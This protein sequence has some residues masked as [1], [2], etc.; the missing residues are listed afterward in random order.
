MS[1]DN[2][3]HLPLLREDLELLRAANAY[4]GSPTWTLHDPVSNRFFRIGAL[5]FHLLSR[6]SAQ[7]GEQLIR[8][9]ANETV[10]TPT[11]ED[12]AT[13]IQ[14][15]HTHQLTVQSYRQQSF[16]YAAQHKSYQASR[17][18]RLLSQYLFFRIP[19]FRPD[20]F[21]NRTYP[22]VRKFFSP[23]FLY[24]VTLIGIAGVYLVSRQWD[25]F[26]NTFL[27]FFTLQ[28]ILIYAVALIGTKIFHE[29]GHAYTAKHYGCRIPSMGVAFM[30]M[31]PMMYSDMSDT[32]RLHSR[33]ERMHVAAAGIMNEL[34]LA[35][36]CLF[37][38]AFLPEGILR[39][40]CFVVATTSLISSLL[41]NITP[42][43]RF[44]GYYLLSDWWG[45]DNLQRRSFQL[46]QWKLR[47]LLFG[48]IEEK[49][50]VLSPSQELKL[51]C[52]AW[53]TWLYRLVLFL[54]IA[55]LIYHFFFKLLGLILFVVEI[56]LLIL[57]PI[58]KEI[59]HWWTL[60]SSLSTNRRRLGVFLLVSVMCALFLP[61]NS[62]IQ[63][64]G[65]LTSAT[66]ATLYPSESAQIAFIAVQQGQ[67][68]EKDQ[69]LMVLRSPKLDKDIALTR[70][71][72]EFLEVRAL[73]AVANRQDQ[74]DLPVI[75]EQI[76]AEFSKL[77]GLENKQARLTLRAPFTGI[78]AEMDEV[79][80]VHQWVHHATPLCLIL[81]PH[82]A[83]IRG[84]IAENE[85][86]RIVLGQQALFY[87]EDSQLPKL[88][89]SI[90]RIDW[91]NIKNLD[92]TYLASQY[93]GDIA[94]RRHNNG[95]MVPVYGI[96]LNNVSSTVPQQEIRGDI[97]I[98]GKPVSVASRV[99]ET[100][101]SV[102]IRESGF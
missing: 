37:I 30:V 38:W 93:G 45:I 12:V 13:L 57:M 61:W 75:L 98:V 16:K 82:S 90:H 27:H 60:R 19:L 17:W 43:M 63:I 21:L 84:V 3:Q 56:L 68:V 39:S 40:V 11:H 88:T 78:V 49:P 59:Q 34:M 92:L 50:E 51:I 54:G 70:K 100:V 86:K 79:L 8:Q 36:I 14:F 83:E 102:I 53:L 29:L 31:V 67:H 65:V 77:A 69:V 41:I 18:Q 24:C 55:L 52:Y 23:V 96:Y 2:A 58:F 62:R 42:F 95:S 87:P 10:F 48:L 94:V 1:S 35:G 73:R 9:V 91:G 4:D 26:L 81:D 15:L 64:P 22:F 47:Y 99:Y 25:V 85:L 33:R 97:L 32:W 89:A 72:I 101:V 71:Q 80:R 28:G 20:A 44:D 5:I 76:A 66:Y 46:A 74:D 7:N 6:W